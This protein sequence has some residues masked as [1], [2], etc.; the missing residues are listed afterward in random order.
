[1]PGD[2]V[3]VALLD[4]H[5]VALAGLEA[6]YA[7]SGKPITVCAKGGDVSL[8]LAGPG[9]E[10]HVVVLDLHLSP[11]RF[12][13]EELKTLVAQ[14]RQV[15]VYAPQDSQAA[16]QTS[17]DLGAFTFLTKAEGERHLV[18]ATLAAAEGA[19]YTSPA[20][21]A[22]LGGASQPSRPML[23]PR[24]VEVLLEWF[25]SDSKTE[26]A[27]ALAIS[28]RTVNTY[29]D[30]IRVKY[31]DAGRPARTKAHLIAR[32]VQDGLVALDEL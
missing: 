22:T 6:W 10:A 32:A 24:E 14:D 30:R 5:P 26:V 15:I 9:R 13:Y 20:L 21:A 7:A 11:G 8:A 3:R 31:A 1:M 17:L 2:T 19:P 28:V 25:Q 16:A 4:A 18:E 23:A 12:A 27:A 29:L